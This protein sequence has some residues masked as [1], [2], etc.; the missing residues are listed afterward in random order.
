MGMGDIRFTTELVKHLVP[1]GLALRGMRL[2]KA[3]ATRGADI[4][5]LIW[6]NLEL[7]DD[8]QVKSSM[9]LADPSLLGLTEKTTERSLGITRDE[10]TFPAHPHHAALS[11]RTSRAG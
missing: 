7:V 1:I 9:E 8:D 10:L 2:A 5:A 4:T 11:T 3:K 6:V